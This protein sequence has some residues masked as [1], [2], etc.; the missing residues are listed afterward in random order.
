[1]WLEHS[2]H[3]ALLDFDHEEVEDRVSRFVVTVTAGE[4]AGRP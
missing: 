1:V 4:E 3:A 2:Y